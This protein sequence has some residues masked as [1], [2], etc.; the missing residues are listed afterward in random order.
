MPVNSTKITANTQLSSIGGTFD[1]F[2]FFNGASASVVHVFDNNIPD[3]VLP[4]DY[5]N[6]TTMSNGPT[7]GLSVGML[8]FGS[9]IPDGATV[10]SITD[11]TT[12]ELSAT[13]TGGAKVSQALT[14]VSVDNPIGKFSTAANTSDDI[15]GLGII[16]RNGIKIVANNFTTLEV[17]ALTN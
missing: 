6:G 8:V 2:I 11:P 4:Y 13:T 12:F 1:G 5:N 9:G 10:A 7:D 16:C 3:V 17:F 15:R 14:F